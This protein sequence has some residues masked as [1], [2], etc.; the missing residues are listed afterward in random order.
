MKLKTRMNASFKNIF[1]LCLSKM[2][3]HT[4]LDEPP[5]ESI[6]MMRSCLRC[7][8]AFMSWIPLGY[9]FETPLLPGLLQY[10]LVSNNFRQLS[11]EVLLEVVSLDLG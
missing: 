2:E 10:Y 5:S 8:K 1:D 11:L 7:I 6:T 9:I 3:A 4:Q